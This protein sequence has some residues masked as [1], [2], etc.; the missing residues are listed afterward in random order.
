MRPFRKLLWPLLPF[1]ALACAPRV[2]LAEPPHGARTEAHCD[3]DDD[4]DVDTDNDDDHGGGS[5][6]V[7]VEA[8]PKGAVNVHEFAGSVHVTS[9]ARNAIQ[10]R[11]DFGP[12]C[13]VDIS[14]SGDRHEIR[15]TC[16]HGPGTGD[17]EIQVPQGSS[18]DVRTMSADVSVQGVNG[19]VHLQTVTGNIEIKGGAPS[20]V[21]ARST[22]GDMKI[23]AA[24][25]STRA[26]SV[27]GDVHVS[28]ARGRATLRTVN[29]DVTLSGGDFSAI[30]VESVSGDFVFKGAVTSQGTCEVQTHSGDVTLH[31]PPTTGAD[32]EMRSVS[33]GLVIDM[34]SGRKTGE[35]ELDGRIGPGGSRLQLRTFSGD[36]QILQ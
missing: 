5:V 26:Q 4:V 14:P 35:R 9:W 1:A 25:P 3:D 32:V 11:G 36:I 29:G 34:G 10:V 20:E 19:A 21:E 15:L 17:M 16:A 28:G 24:S 27:S 12:D 18:L 23:E 22:S 33:G 2:A 13:H 6:N 7:T 8:K 30:D 31:L